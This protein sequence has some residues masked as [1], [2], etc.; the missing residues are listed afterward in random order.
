MRKLLYECKKGKKDKLK[1]LEYALIFNSIKVEDTWIHIDGTIS[2]EQIGNIISELSEIYN[3]CGYLS[4]NELLHIIPLCERS[5]SL[6][7]SDVQLPYDANV[8]DYKVTKIK[9]WKYDEN[10]PS[11]IN[12]ICVKTCRPYYYENWQDDYMDKY[13]HTDFVSINRLFGDYICNY[14]K[15]PTKNE[16][17]LYIYKKVAM[18]S[19][20]LL[21]LPICV[22]QFVEEVFEEY[23]DIMKDITS[24]EFVKRWNDSVSKD[25][26]IEI[27]NA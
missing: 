21:T 23:K 26:R 22:E 4:R 7:E 24:K 20:P 14:G 5:C 19:S 16:F 13:G 2:E 17:F 8:P 15:Y 10:T 11:V 9:N 27:Q 18:K 25:K 6:A 12:D 3:E 1:N